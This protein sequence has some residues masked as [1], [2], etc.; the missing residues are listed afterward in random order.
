MINIFIGY[1][2]REAIMYVPTVLLD[3]LV[4]QFRSHHLR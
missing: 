2:H 1:D 4:N 3:I